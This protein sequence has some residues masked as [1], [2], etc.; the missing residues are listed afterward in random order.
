MKE[1]TEEHN[2]VD[3]IGHGIT[4]SRANNIAAARMKCHNFK[5]LCI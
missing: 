3:T 4:I 1:N 5:I 2:H